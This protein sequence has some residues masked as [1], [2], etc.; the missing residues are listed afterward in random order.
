M[1]V[2]LVQRSIRGVRT[3]N[4]ANFPA[5]WPFVKKGAYGQRKIGPYKIEKNRWPGP[6]RQF[7]ELSP[8]WNK[9]NPESLHNYTGVR[10]EGYIDASTG[11]F[12]PVPEM[13]VEIVAPDLTGF[14]LSPYVSYRT[15]V[16]IDKRRMAYEAKVREKGSEA[17]ADLYTNEDQRWPPPKMTAETLF[18]LIYADD[19]RRNFKEGKYG[20]VSSISDT[21]NPTAKSEIKETAR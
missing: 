20:Q 12:V 9:E 10:R 3:L 15:D 11:S 21:H 2:N 5:P 16:E 7:P 18:E 13:R 6:D 8:K 19:V 17:L 4:Q 14:Q 1:A